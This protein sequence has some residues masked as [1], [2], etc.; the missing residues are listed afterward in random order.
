MADNIQINESATLAYIHLHGKT[1]F[2]PVNMID[3]F[4]ICLGVP[5]GQFVQSPKAIFR[6]LKQAA[7]RNMAI[8][9]AHFCLGS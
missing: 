1:A 8:S 5:L 4:L 3:Y 7:R 6:D 2:N 9:E